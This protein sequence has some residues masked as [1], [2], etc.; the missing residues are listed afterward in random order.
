MTSSYDW[1]SQLFKILNVIGQ[2]DTRCALGAP[3]KVAYEQL[4]PGEIP[5]HIILTGTAVLKNSAGKEIRKLGVGDIVLL[6]QGSP[7]TLEDG[8]GKEAVPLTKSIGSV[9][10]V[11]ENGS[12]G[13]H[14][15]MLCGRFIITPPH[16]RLLRDYLPMELVISPTM[17]SDASLDIET[18]QLMQ[19]LKLMRSESMTENLGG[20]AILNALSVT[21]FA[22]TLRYASKIKEAPVGLLALAGQPRLAPAL[23][24]MFNDPS[25]AWTLPELASNCNMSRATFMRQF[26]SKLGK[27]PSELLLDIRMSLAANALKNPHIT[28][29]D[30]SEAVGYKSVAAFR[31][32]FTQKV[33]ETPGNWRRNA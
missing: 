3:W 31:R 13:E 2:I 10:T 5:Y 28:T 11:A 1:L 4:A 7:H 9:L 29:E 33:G 25:R 19:L 26:Q 15:D 30:V 12:E 14:L 17:D 16:D 22:L 20:M 27:S 21:L 24:A 32:A 18:A 8:S 6:P 23:S